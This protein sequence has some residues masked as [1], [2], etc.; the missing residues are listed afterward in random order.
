[1]KQAR[2]NFGGA[3]VSAARLADDVL[4]LVVPLTPSGNLVDRWKLS[5]NLRKLSK[6]KRDGRSGV[7][8]SV[9]QLWPG[10]QVDPRP[11]AQRISIS[12]IRC[13]DTARLVDDDNVANGCKYAR[14]AL[15]TVGLVPDDS[16]AHVVMGPAETR[17]RG[18]WGDLEGPATHLLIRR[19]A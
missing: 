18:N 9:A 13:S 17:T 2:P 19:L 4:R 10:G 6:L 3:S 12:I 15:V 7:H 16:P 8:F 11:W 1:M 14:D 5:R